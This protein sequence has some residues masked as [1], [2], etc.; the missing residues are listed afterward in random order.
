MFATPGS[1][2]Q[3][4]RN[5]HDESAV[6]KFQNAAII[7]T[8]KREKKE[9]EYDLLMKALERGLLVISKVIEDNPQLNEP[10]KERI[11]INQQN[12]C[13]I[14]NSN[15]ENLALHQGISAWWSD[16]F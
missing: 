7:F 6:T 2:Y 16:E 5:Y 14:C 11:E 9:K 10:P 8:H 15:C 12:F 4:M 13:Y 3:H 1:Y